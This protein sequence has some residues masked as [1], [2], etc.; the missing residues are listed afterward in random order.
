MAQIIGRSANQLRLKYITIP[1]LLAIIFNVS[2]CRRAAPPSFTSGEALLELTEDLE[3]DEEIALYK[4]LQKQVVNVL[5]RNC[6]TPEKPLLLGQPEPTEPE[7][8]RLNRGYQLYSKY[9]VQCHGVNGD[10][11]GAVAEHLDPKPRNYTH[12]VFKFTST[13]YGRKPRRADLILT[14]RRGVT[15]TS[16]PSFDRFSKEDMEAVVDYVLVLTYRGELERT[17]ASIAF[18]DEELPDEEGIEEVI[19]DVLQPWQDSA[20]EIV[21]PETMMPPMTDES[22]LAGHQ[23][24]LKHACNKCHGVVWPWWF[25]GQRRS[26][27]GRMGKQ[28]SSS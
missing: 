9:C 15:G 5:L 17:L 10:G 12:G 4:D 22:A 26:R 28:S 7:K 19:A 25:G 18:E 24:F 11:N 2:G 27:Y 6:G 21:M 8:A 20:N 13:P 3:D 16:M 23:L 14:I 1:V